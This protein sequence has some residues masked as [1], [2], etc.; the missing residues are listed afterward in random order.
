VAREP[1]PEVYRAVREALQ[2]NFT[3]EVKWKGIRGVKLTI[4]FE[5][6]LL[7]MKE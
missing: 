7:R 1:S 5:H 3:S 2:K 6:R 4:N